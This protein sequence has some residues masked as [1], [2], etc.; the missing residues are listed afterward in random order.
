MRRLS[1]VAVVCSLAPLAVGCGDRPG[2]MVTGTGVAGASGGAGTTGAA[3]T[4]GPGTAGTTGAAGTSAAGGTGGV[5]GAT[6]SGGAPA[7]DV[8][9]TVNAAGRHQTLVGFGGA[10]AFYTNYLAAQSGAIY[11]ML[12]SDLG[13]DLLRIGNWYQ[14]QSMTGTTTST[15]FSDTATVQVLQKAKTALGHAPKILMSSWSPPAYLKSNN[16]TK[17]SMGTLLSTNG[18]FAY[19]QF[20]D[21]WARSLTAY[22]AMGVV[23]DFISIQNEPDY[24]NSGWE[25][26]QLDATEGTNAG[27]GK[28]L[29]AVAS[30]I[31]A[32]SLASKPQI[33]G[34]ETSGIA[35]SRV[36]NYL[37]Q[38][39]AGNFTTVAHHL[40]NGGASG[41]DPAPDS[42]A[43]PMAAVA[44]AA[45]SKP[46]FMTEYSPSTP[47][48]F[49][50]A[51]LIHD[52][53]TTE[54]VA[55]YFYW[56]LIWAP[57]ASGST[58]SSL[59]TIQSAN[60][61]SS[62]TINDPYYAVK[63]FA[64]WTDPGWVRVDV[65]SSLAAVR[66]SAFVSPD[67]KSL[68][69][70][71]LNTDPGQHVVAVAPGGFAFGT[72]SGYR[73]SGASERAASASLGGGT[74]ITMPGTSLATVVL[75]P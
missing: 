38:M 36:Q 48:L 57:P 30:A 71:L 72:A 50:T 75:G 29:D 19:A 5:A 63:H 43:T 40:Y 4:A 35:N 66:A 16:A 27:Y 13:L 28:A 8:T 23:P 25:T 14:N 31:A 53:L 59:V 46:I 15:P 74:T 70:V 12:F 55:A 61:G 73:S 11:T 24:Y 49:N 42:W 45:G 39:T 22:A 7:S 1:F 3:G 33:I 52:A 2:P 37:A 21:W 62:Y 32:S 68:T 20:G 17:A 56:D 9:A 64:R 26:C 44:T 67:G 65:S 10:V 51:L 6:G 34:P 69:V 60:A 54:G 47:T 41:S 58:A 18:A